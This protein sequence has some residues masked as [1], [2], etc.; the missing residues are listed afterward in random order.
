LKKKK[1]P[2]K[3]NQGSARFPTEQKKKKVHEPF[4]RGGKPAALGEER[5]TQKKK[6]LL[7]SRKRKGKN[8]R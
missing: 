8:Y 5:K 7:T 6:S 4:M 2:R 3:K 1:T